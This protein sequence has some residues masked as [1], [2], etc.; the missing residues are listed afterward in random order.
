[1]NYK[2]FKQLANNKTVDEII[3]IIRKNPEKFKI[4]N[5][6][7]NTYTICTKDNV[8][9]AKEGSVNNA[10]APLRLI[11]EGRALSIEAKQ[12]K[13][14]AAELRRQTE[15]NVTSFIG[16][17]I[18]GKEIINAEVEGEE[19]KITIVGGKT[20]GFKNI[21]KLNSLIK[22]GDIKM[23]SLI[24]EYN[25][26]RYEVKRSELISEPKKQGVYYYFNIK[27]INKQ[28]G[29][30]VLSGKQS[31]VPTKMSYIEKQYRA[32]LADY[33]AER[34][35]FLAKKYPITDYDKLIREVNNHRPNRNSG[36]NHKYLLN[37]GIIPGYHYRDEVNNRTVTFYASRDYTCAVVEYDNKEEFD[38]E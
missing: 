28:T 1:M 24:K 15:D 7:Y 21:N 8:A 6:Y 30:V 37:K 23:S 12:A 38:N 25:E 10:K 20:Y 36:L 3:K 33:G 31:A 13:K 27:V 17:T 14:A 29:E 26:I 34:D 16:K 4:K 19:I 22:S 35:E 9:I 32:L 2:Q 11:G 18:W 5:T